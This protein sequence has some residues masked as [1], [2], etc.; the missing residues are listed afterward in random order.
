MNENKSL[1][2]LKKYKK[3]SG[4]LGLSEDE[5]L[6]DELIDFFD[7][8]DVSERDVSQQNIKKSKYT[9]KDFEEIVNSNEDL[10]LSKY[11]IDEQ[12]KS[13]RTDIVEF[14]YSLSNDQMEKFTIFEL[15]IILYLL[16]NHFNKYQKKEKKRIISFISNFVKSKRMD[17]SYNNLNV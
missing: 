7:K 17:D 6:F 2:L 10:D 3:I 14:W 4:L 1:E 11:D 9:E 13:N 12:I 5:K 8:I 16:S 15:N